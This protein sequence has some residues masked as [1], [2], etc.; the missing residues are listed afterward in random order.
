MAHWR[1]QRGFNFKRWLKESEKNDPVLLITG[2][3]AVPFLEDRP[4]SGQTDWNRLTGAFRGSFLNRAIWFN[5]ETAAPSSVIWAVMVG[6]LDKCGNCPNHFR[7]I[8]RMDLVT[9]T[10]NAH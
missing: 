8:I 5:Q 2:P 4:V 9:A 10:V 7:N 1:F 3:D 6:P